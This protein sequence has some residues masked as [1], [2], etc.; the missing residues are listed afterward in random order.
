M[1]SALIYV[2]VR[3]RSGA[4]WV[5]VTASENRDAARVAAAGAYRDLR[6]SRDESPTQVRLVSGDQLTREG[7]PRDVRLADAVVARNAA[8]RAPPPQ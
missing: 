8:E 2:Q 4:R 5:T 1:S 6:N 3:Y 7:G